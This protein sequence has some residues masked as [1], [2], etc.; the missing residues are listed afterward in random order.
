[1]SRNVAGI[2]QR[3]LGEGELNRVSGFTKIPFGKVTGKVMRNTGKHKVGPSGRVEVWI[4]SGRN[5]V[6][7]PGLLVIFCFLGHQSTASSLL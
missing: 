6:R 4:W 2:G 5:M 3:L 7:V 1:M